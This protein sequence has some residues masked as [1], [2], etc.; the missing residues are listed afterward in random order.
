M[1]LKKIL[2]ISLTI[3]LIT[4]TA[5]AYSPFFIEKDQKAPY[6]G[7]LFSEA[8][9]KD[10][11]NALI[12]KDATENILKSKEQTIIYY[13]ESL[14]IRNQQVKELLEQQQQE[15]TR[16]YLYIGAGVISTIL[17]FYAT[18]KIIQATK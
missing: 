3:A 17:M 2:L 18:S 13:K 14:D 11:R 4:N 10:L 15:E 5:F 8:D 7:Y 9:V 1:L 6:T 16:K 12:D